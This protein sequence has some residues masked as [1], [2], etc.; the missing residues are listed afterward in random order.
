MT[1]ALRFTVI[2]ILFTL[3]LAGCDLFDSESTAVNP[4]SLPD[5]S[6]KY[7]PARDPGSDLNF[8]V[9]SAKESNQR[10]LMLVG[11]DWCPWCR[12][13]DK[14]IKENDELYTLLHENYVLLKVYYGRENYNRDFLA[15]FPRMIATPHIFV[16]E[17][18]GSLLHSQGTEELEKGRSYDALKFTAFLQRWLPKK[19]AA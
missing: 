4:A 14:F 12:A 5:F 11:G 1:N 3:L 8:A 16:L 10:I 19:D 17:S 18:D 15:G 7:D 9:A 2:P 13:M 6:Q